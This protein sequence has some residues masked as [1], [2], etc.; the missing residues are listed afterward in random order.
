ML[1]KISV[2][3]IAMWVLRTLSSYTMNG[4][5]NIL[6]V[7]AVLTLLLRMISGRQVGDRTSSSPGAG[8]FQPLHG[9]SE[10]SRSTRIKAGL[11]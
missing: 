8:M 11:R 10:L 7:I 1:W 6:L 4:F 9:S 5:I 2:T 3:V